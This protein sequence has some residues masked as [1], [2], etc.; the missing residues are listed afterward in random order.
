[1]PETPTDISTIHGYI[2]FSSPDSKKLRS[3]IRRRI[4]DGTFRTW[5]VD[6]IAYTHVGGNDER[7]NNW[8]GRGWV[9]QLKDQFPGRVK[10]SVRVRNGEKEVDQVFGQYS[11]AFSAR[12]IAQLRDLVSAVEIQVK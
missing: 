6:R 1:M 10:F 4:K 2:T 7:G 11:G 8:E 9:W 5:K 3:E 12:V